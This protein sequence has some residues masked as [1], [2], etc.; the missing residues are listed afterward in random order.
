MS[1]DYTLLGEVI[2]SETV[3][4]ELCPRRKVTKLKIYS[5]GRGMLEM[6]IEGRHRIDKNEKIR[7]RYETASNGLNVINS[8]D[9]IKQGNIVYSDVAD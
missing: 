8:Y 2:S 7:V 6:I 9:I 3:E 5:E 1:S 4:I